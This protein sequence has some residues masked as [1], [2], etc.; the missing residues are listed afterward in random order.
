MDISKQTNTI[1]NQRGATIEL[2]TLWAGYAF[3][4]SAAACLV[5]STGGSAL[6]LVI[7]ALF[8]PL[9]LK[10]AILVGPVLFCSMFDDYLLV[11]GG[12][13]VSRFLTIFFILGAAI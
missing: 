5:G 12:A 7:T 6:M 11:A 9:M 13:S 2:N 4:L 3:A 10:P 1:R 8:A